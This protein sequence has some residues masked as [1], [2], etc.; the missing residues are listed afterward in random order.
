MKKRILIIVA[1]LAFAA[2]EGPM[3]PPGPQGLPGAA[4]H[5]GHDGEDGRDGQNGRDGQGTYWTREPFTIYPD[6]WK[7]AEG[8][9]GDLNTYFRQTFKW[10][11]LTDAV[12]QNGLVM[13]YI[14]TVDQNGLRQN[15]G[16]PFVLHRGDVDEKTGKDILWTET[17]DFDFRPEFITFNLTYSDFNTTIRPEG[18]VTFHVLILQEK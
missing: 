6:E 15:I 2:C 4:G 12:C 3:G 8:K 13:A 1:A 11:K 5:D 14:E 17:F 7:V 10:N 16:M 18:P 9:P